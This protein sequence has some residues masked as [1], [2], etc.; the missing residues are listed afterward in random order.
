MSKELAL[1]QCYCEYAAAFKEQDIV[2]GDGNP[3]SGILLIGEAP[4]KDEVA[5]KKPFVGKAGKNLAEFLSVLEIDRQMLYIT[6]AIKYRLGKVSP[7]S[8][9]IV[10]RPAQPSDIAMNRPYL[11]REI[12][13]LKPK[14]ILTLGN[15]PLKALTG[16]QHISIGAV[17]GKVGTWTVNEKNLQIFPLYHPASIIYNPALRSVYVED[18]K[19]LKL[20]LEHIQ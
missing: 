14:C 18:M 11:L 17:H 7:K 16:E 12:E 6:N 19:K 20:V 2:L 9:R 5:Q 15:I 3:E 13:I 8:G 10:N 4:G 1:K